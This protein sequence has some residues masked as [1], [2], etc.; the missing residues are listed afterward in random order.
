[1]FD[2]ASDALITRVGS[3]TF[4]EPIDELRFLAVEHAR[5]AI[6]H[7][8]LASILI[9]DNRSLPPTFRRRHERRERP[10]FERWTRCILTAFPGLTI[11]ESTTA[12]FASMH[13]LNSV[14]NWPASAHKLSDLA[15]LLADMVIG[16]V[17]SI[18]NDFA[19]SA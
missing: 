14:G 17:T 7:R 8:E 1:M 16:S 13:M 2:E 9:R 10:Y 15:N 4:D 3:A 18:G 12:T 6:E 11:Q 19:D 5:F